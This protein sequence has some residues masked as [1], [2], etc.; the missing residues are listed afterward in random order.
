MIRVLEEAITKVLSLPEAA[1]E[2]AARILLWTLEKHAAPAPLD[3][4]TSAAID[5]GIAQAARGDFATDAE[6][7]DL[8]KRHGL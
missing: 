4:E 8:R 2:E 3:G 6:I 1:Q 5:E 7:A